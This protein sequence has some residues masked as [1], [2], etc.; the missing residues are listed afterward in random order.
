MQGTG[1]LGLKNEDV[2][3]RTISLSHY[4]ETMDMQALRSLLLQYNNQ[5][6]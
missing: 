3:S 5:L 4:Q 1:Y 2:S 6:M